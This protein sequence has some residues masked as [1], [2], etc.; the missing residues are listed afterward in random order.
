M[1]RFLGEYEAT[2]DAKGRFLFPTG[3][4]R[5][6]PEGE[7]G[8]FFINRG[9]E[10]CLTL[11][12]MKNW[13]PIFEEISNKNDFD[14]KVREFRRYFLNGIT[15]DMDSAGRLLLPKNL[16][17]Y[18]GLQKDIVLLSAIDKIEI[19]DKDKYQQ[20]FDTFSPEAFSALAQEVMA[21]KKEG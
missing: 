17:E 20:L 19:W 16:M 3:F 18:A 4:R 10:R 8:S 13:E 15:V 1:I 21:A 9:F 2:L 14:A 6:I 12:P 7:T 11:Y 5:Q